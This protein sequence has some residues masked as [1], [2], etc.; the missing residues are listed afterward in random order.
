MPYPP[1]SATS[2][3]ASSKAS[4]A[5]CPEKAKLKS[6]AHA[7]VAQAAMLPITSAMSEVKIAKN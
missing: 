4:A 2:P 6:M 1:N 7:T 3:V 5:A